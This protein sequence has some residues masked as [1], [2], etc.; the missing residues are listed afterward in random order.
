LQSFPENICTILTG[1]HFGRNQC[2]NELVTLFQIGIQT[3][4]EFDKFGVIKFT[5]PI[6]VNP[7]DKKVQVFILTDLGGLVYG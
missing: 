2:G 5:F 6:I 7:Q 4:P 3:L 1:S